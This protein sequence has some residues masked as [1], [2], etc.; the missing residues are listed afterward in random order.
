MNISEH[1]TMAEATK[2]Q[3]ATRNS[4]PNKPGPRELANMIDTAENIFEPVRKH[5]GVPIFI[6]SFYRSA[7]VNAVLG[8]A[9]RSQHCTGQ[10]VDVDGDVFGGV[11]NREIF[12]YVLNNLE[13]DQLIWEFGDNNNPDWV[14]FSYARGNN[15][16]IVMR[17]MKV[18]YQ[19]S[20]QEYVHE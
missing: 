11:T 12:E 20:Y 18:G 4:L 7:G 16:R 3:V 2:S 1:I 6:S 9:K 8:G 17:A 5:F 19:T 13:F 15:R 14:H 10:A